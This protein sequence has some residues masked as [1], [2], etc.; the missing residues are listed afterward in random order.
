M[1]TVRTKKPPTFVLQVYVADDKPNSRLAVENLS[2]ICAKKLAGRCK[3]KVVDVTQN[4]QVAI[5]NNLI[6]L[7]AVVRVHPPPLRRFI[8]NC[9]N[10]SK[11]LLALGL[12]GEGGEQLEDHPR[13][14]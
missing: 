13:S 11:A 5:E 8:G 9:A 1:A 12:I 2:G 10:E 7:P 4:P 3:I 14:G 6:A